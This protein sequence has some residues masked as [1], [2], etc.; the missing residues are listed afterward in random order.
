M[1]KISIEIKD[2]DFSRLTIKEST[3][4]PNIFSINYK[5]DD[6]TV[7]PLLIKTPFIDCVYPGLF[8]STDKD[9]KAIDD[10]DRMSWRAYL[11]DEVMINKLNELQETIDKNKTVFTGPVNTKDKKTKEFDVQNIIGEYTDKNGVVQQYARFKFRTQN[12]NPDV[13]ETAFFDMK[14]KNMEI[15]KLKEF[16]TKFRP[17]EFRYRIVFSMYGWKMKSTHL[18]GV[19][20][21]IEQMQIEVTASSTNI[22]ELLKNV[23]LFDSAPD[24]EI[25]EVDLSKHIEDNNDDDDAIS[26]VQQTKEEI[27]DEEDEE[28]EEEEEEEIKPAKKSSIKVAPVK[29]PRKKA[30]SA[31]A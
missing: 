19:S 2:V 21:S 6:G 12:A 16:E 17:R 27:E 25:E 24:A 4:N 28:E 18:F 22:K 3:K 8:F 29:Q 23:S 30:A 5:F 1:S 14:G 7:K 9:G 10:K 13:F 20:F 26:N 11:T 15:T 31:N